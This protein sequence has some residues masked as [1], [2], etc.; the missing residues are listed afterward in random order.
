LQA[1]LEG[2]RPDIVVSDYRLMGE[3]GFEVIAAL[4]ST[5]GQDLPALLITGDTDPALVRH[6][7]D[8]GIV[9]LHKPVDLE[10]LQAYMEDATA[11]G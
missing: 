1:A 5:F 11:P 8:R 2:K 4:R 9:V 7:A 10:T 3:T 6:M